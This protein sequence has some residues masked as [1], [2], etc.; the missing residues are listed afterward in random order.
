[1]G[2]VKLF[3]R[4]KLIGGWSLAV[5][6]DWS[7]KV[8]RVNITDEEKELYEKEIGDEI[9]TYSDF[10]DW[11]LKAREKLAQQRHQHSEAQQQQPINSETSSDNEQ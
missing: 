10:F 11:W 9:L 3:I 8:K 1:M 6:D 5:R 2:H 4:N 7:L